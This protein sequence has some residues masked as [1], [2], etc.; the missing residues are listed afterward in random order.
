MLVSPF[1][2]FERNGSQN[3]SGRA[4]TCETTTAHGLGSLKKWSCRSA[5]AANQ[6]MVKQSTRFYKAKAVPTGFFKKSAENA[7]KCR[8]CEN[9]IAV[10]PAQNLEIPISSAHFP[11]NIKGQEGMQEICCPRINK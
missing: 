3:A 11:L 10:F 4:T 6:R 9:L 8:L 2:S 5:A 7:G 1:L